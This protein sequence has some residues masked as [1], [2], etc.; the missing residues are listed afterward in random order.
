MSVPSEMIINALANVYAQHRSCILIY[1]KS[2]DM[3]I[4]LRE[5]WFLIAREYL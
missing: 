5:V 1:D 3:N 2:T 4:S